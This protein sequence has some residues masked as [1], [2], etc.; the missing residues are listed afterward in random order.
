M[1]D[2]IRAWSVIRSFG[3]ALIVGLVTGLVTAGLFSN[4]LVGSLELRTSLL[5]GLGV[6]IVLTLLFTVVFDRLSRLVGRLN[7]ATEQKR[8]TLGLERER[9]EQRMRSMFQDRR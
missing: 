5:V 1:S 6:G 3:Y 8:K 9:L 4:H 2:R 7:Q